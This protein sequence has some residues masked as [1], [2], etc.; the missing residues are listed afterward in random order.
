MG[1]FNLIK[2]MKIYKKWMIRILTITLLTGTFIYS[3]GQDKV[4]WN[5]PINPLS[6]EWK[7]LTYK[8]QL[9]AYNIPAE[10]LEK[11]STEELVKTCLSYP[12]WR[13]INAYDNLQIGFANVIGLFNG[14]HELFKRNDAAKELI[15]VF[16]K[17]DPTAINTNWTPLQKGIFSFQFTRIEMLLSHN[18]IIKKLDSNDINQLLDKAVSKY[19]SMRQLPDTYSLYDLS[20]LAGLYLN[21]LDKDGEFVKND[22]KLLSFKGTFMT[23]DITTLE[24]IIEEI[25]K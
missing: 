4:V 2:T 25:T 16:E 11:I 20:P 10:I 7:N 9:K 18:E 14:F 15:K 22:R 17:L 23:E 21:I 1:K 6:D 12:E 13:L 8:E 3:H 19:K 24:K 5:Y